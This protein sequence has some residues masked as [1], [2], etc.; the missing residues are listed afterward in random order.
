[1]KYF[2][3]LLH[4]ADGRVAATTH[5]QRRHSYAYRYRYSYK[6]RDSYERCEHK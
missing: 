6:Y 5:E 1:M 2:S 3:F 4:F